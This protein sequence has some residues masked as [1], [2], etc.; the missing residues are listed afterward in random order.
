MLVDYGLLLV[1][2]PLDFFTCSLCAGGVMILIMPNYC[3]TNTNTNTII[4]HQIAGLV[5]QQCYNV[6]FAS[7]IPSNLP[8]AGLLFSEIKK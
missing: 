6:V 2:P 1:F 8:T 3:D 5:A 4:N 7:N